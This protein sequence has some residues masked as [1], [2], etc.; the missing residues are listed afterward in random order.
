MVGEY[1]SK[2]WGACCCEASAR[3]EGGTCA[4]WSDPPHRARI[5]LREA[6][7]GPRCI[8]PRHDVSD[9]G[10]GVGIHSLMGCGDFA[11]HVTH[12]DALDYRY[13]FTAHHCPFVR[14]VSYFCIVLSMVCST[15][16]LVVP[17]MQRVMWGRNDRG[18]CY[19]SSAIIQK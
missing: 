4:V 5:S 2:H 3:I 19:A 17:L 14:D 10:V 13:A 8:Y 1:G 15:P 11:K 18:C 7:E 6:C 9:G 16:D 12:H